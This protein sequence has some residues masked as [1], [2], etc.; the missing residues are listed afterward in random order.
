MELQRGFHHVAVSVFSLSAEDFPPGMTTDRSPMTYRRQGRRY[1]PR[2]RA[3]NRYHAILE[4]PSHC[5]LV[6]ARY[7]NMLPF[8]SGHLGDLGGLGNADAGRGIRS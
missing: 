3:P 5:Q 7:A 6:Y 4:A 1:D 8:A 2:S